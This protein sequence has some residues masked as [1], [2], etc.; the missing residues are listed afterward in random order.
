VYLVERHLRREP[1]LDR[2]IRGRNTHGM[3]PI[4]AKI[5]AFL[6]FVGTA[7]MVAVMLG[8]VAH[9]TLGVA[10]QIIREEAMISALL[11]G[12]FLVIGMF[13]NTSGNR[14]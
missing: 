9:D 12:G 10:R 4:L 6:T 11:I 7:G 14:K 2:S 13:A 5:A 3:E 8:Y 1:E